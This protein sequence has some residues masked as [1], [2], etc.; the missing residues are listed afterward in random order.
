[1]PAAGGTGDADECLAVTAGTAGRFS[2]VEDCRWIGLVLETRHQASV[3]ALV[4]RGEAIKLAEDGRVGAGAVLAEAPAE[5]LR[6]PRLNAEGQNIFRAPR[7]GCFALSWDGR[8]RAHDALW[9]H[10]EAHNAALQRPGE[11]RAAP[12]QVWTQTGTALTEEGWRVLAERVGFTDK[13]LTHD[14]PADWPAGRCIKHSLEDTA[15]RLV[16][17]TAQGPRQLVL[18]GTAAPYREVLD[19]E[20]VSSREPIA[21]PV[22]RRTWTPEELHKE[23]EPDELAGLAR[24]LLSDG[25]V[26]AQWVEDPRD[27]FVTVP[28]GLPPV[29]KTGG[30]LWGASDGPLPGLP[31]V[32]LRRRAGQK[33]LV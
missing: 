24:L 9:A 5:A 7:Q 25:P 33:A 16:F 23:L 19:G 15:W 12:L 31:E 20:E 8:L 4:K 1:E 10:L 3:V 30:L 32:P 2:T 6:L 26:P 29:R 11:L 21:D 13:A 18:P 17:E 14:Y 28:E 27:P 22:L